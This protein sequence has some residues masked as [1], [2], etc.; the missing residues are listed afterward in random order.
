MSKDTF[1]FLV[2]PRLKSIILSNV[3]VDIAILM[4]LAGEDHEESSQITLHSWDSL[5]HVCSHTQDTEC[6]SHW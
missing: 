4:Q 5:L 2:Q 6:E 3:A 1:H